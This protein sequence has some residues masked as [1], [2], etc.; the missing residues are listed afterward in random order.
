MPGMCPMVI[1][2][3]LRRALSKNFMMTEGDQSKTACGNLQLCA[4]LG[5]G[6]EVAT[7]AMGERRKE[8]TIS[9]S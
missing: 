6:I 8:M 7:H 3:T 4:C 5:S 1:G 2:E 9:K